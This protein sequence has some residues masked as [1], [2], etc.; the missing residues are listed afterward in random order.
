MGHSDES[1]SYSSGGYKWNRC[2]ESEYGSPF[3]NGDVISMV[4]SVAVN[5]V[6][7]LQGELI[8]YKNNRRQG[9]AFKDKQFIQGSF[10]PVVT[11]FKGTRVKILKKRAFI[12]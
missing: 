12:K 2:K 9:V 10:Y 11:A 3:E 7:L 5:F 8:F 6:D 1:Y 4:L